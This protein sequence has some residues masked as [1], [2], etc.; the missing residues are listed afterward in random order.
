MQ[1]QA[2][3]AVTSTPVQDVSKLSQKDAV[4]QFVQEA[5]LT[6]GVVIT[7]AEKLRDLV[8]KD[9]RKTVRTKLFNSIKSGDIK[10]SKEMDD[11]KLKEYCSG[12]INN[13]VKKDT[14]FN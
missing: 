8:T 7:G 12:L 6:S 14:R 2:A 1:T 4:F 9:V 3:S 11:S 5:I 10:L 13:W